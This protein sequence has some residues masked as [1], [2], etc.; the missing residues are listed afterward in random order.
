MV[1]S[2]RRKNAAKKIT[3][4]LQEYLNNKGKFLNTY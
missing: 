3:S 1:E 4:K 2:L